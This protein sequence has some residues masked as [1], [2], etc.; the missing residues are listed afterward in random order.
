MKEAYA[1]YKIKEDVLKRDILDP[2]EYKF[3]FEKYMKE[4]DGTQKIGK[5]TQSLEEIKKQ[6]ELNEKQ[7]ETLYEKTTEASKAIKEK[8]E[9]ALKSIHDEIGRLKLEIEQIK[10]MSMTDE[11]TKCKNRKWFVE[12][13]LDNDKFIKDGTIVIIDMNNFKK[14]NDTYGHA[15]GDNVLK[16]LVNTF[17]TRVDLDVIRYGG[18]EFFL[19]S[20]TK[21]KKHHEK[22]MKD[23]LSFVK[24]QKL[25][26][27]NGQDSFKVSF[28]YG[29]EEFNKGDNYEKVISIA[30]EKMYQNKRRYR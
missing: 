21:D 9:D 26:L 27:V 4:Y 13:W 22:V 11:L 12:N 19:M 28:S 30:D 7:T 15:I 24:R 5:P 8:N 14:I 29:V 1:T 23:I 2:D 16:F 20:K 17:K 3:L 6:S 10:E 18:D 25:K